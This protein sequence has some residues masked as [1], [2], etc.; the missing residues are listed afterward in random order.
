MS[1][2]T[3]QANDC[4]R[5]LK[6]AFPYKLWLD[7]FSKADL[8][9]DIL[10]D[11]GA[12][13]GAQG[14]STEPEADDGHSGVQEASSQP[15]ATSPQA[16]MPPGPEEPPQQGPDAARRRLAARQLVQE[17]PGAVFVSATTEQGLEQL[18]GS[19]IH[20]LLEQTE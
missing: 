2:L 16:A 19:V 10:G 5:D 7:I 18:K 11:S 20:M 14:E 15:E 3:V 9:E 1:Y 17:V 12:N 8:L 4:R 13:C 6:R